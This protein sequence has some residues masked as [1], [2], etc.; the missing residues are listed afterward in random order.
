MN[1]FKNIKKMIEFHQNET[2]MPEFL[3]AHKG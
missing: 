2:G 3:E 1:R